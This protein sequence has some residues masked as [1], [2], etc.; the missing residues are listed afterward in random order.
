MK[1]SEIRRRSS[2]LLL[3]AA[4]VFAGCN[5]QAPPPALPPPVVTVG[6]PILKGIVE[7]DYFTAQTQAVDNVSIRPRVSGYIDNITFRA[8]S[9]VD[10]GE[11]LFVIDPRPYQAALDQAS[12]Q[13]RQAQAQQKLN[14]ANLARAEDL[15]QRHVIAK[16]DYDNAVAQKNVSDAQVIATEAAVE[17]ARLNLGFTQITAPLRGQIGRELVTLGNLVQTDQTELTTLVSIDPIYAYFNVDERSVMRYREARKTQNS[18]ETE[19]AKIPVYLQLEGEKGFPH[20]G[21]IDFVNNTFDPS[22]GTL[23]TRG[24]FPNPTGFIIAGSFGTIRIAGTPKY[25]AVL[26]ADRVIGTDQDQRY[27]IVVQ[28][29]GIAKYQRV[30][31]G[32][33]VEGLR[34]IR[35]GLKGDELVVIEGVSKIRPNSKVTPQMADMAQFAS[36]QLAVQASTRSTTETAG[37]QSSG[38]PESKSVT[39]GSS[40]S[41]KDEAQAGKPKDKQ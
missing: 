16:Q 39:G 25:Q 35:E 26:V 31:T 23:Q 24:L 21:V 36:D 29:D 37:R 3:L 22:T 14:D 2:M 27:A 6:K 4:L 1:R 18:T 30:V 38:A 34:V 12:G 33:L 11:L 41:G 40:P 15:F 13:L 17:S 28:P 10:Q 20:E 9:V 32:P 19:A 5:Q 8:G 7:W